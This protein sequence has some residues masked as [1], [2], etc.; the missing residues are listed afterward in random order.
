M[1]IRGESHKASNNKEYGGIIL[2]GSGKSSRIFRV[3]TAK[4]TPY[5]LQFITFT[6]SKL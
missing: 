4:I 6:E 2:K 5:I 1:I 3:K